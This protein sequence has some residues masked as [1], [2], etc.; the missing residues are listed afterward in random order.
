[1]TESQKLFA[2]LSG[3]VV[4]HLLFFIIVFLFLGMESVSSSSVRNPEQQE[5]APREVTVMLEELIEF[6]QLEPEPEPEPEPVPRSFVSTDL[7]Q[8]EEVAPENPRFESDRNT[9]AATELMPNFELPQ[10][11]GPTLEG[12]EAIPFLQL[13]NREYIE[14]SAAAAAADPT[15][16]QS[17]AAPAAASTQVG[18]DD[19]NVEGQS[20]APLEEI[21]NVTSR[22]EMAETDGEESETSQVRSF[23]DPNGGAFSIGAPTEK[24]DKERIAE[25]SEGAEEVG[26]RTDEAQEKTAIAQEGDGS[27]KGEAQSDSDNGS[28]QKMIGDEGLFAADFTPEERQNIVNGK[29]T[30]IGQ[31]AVDAE[32]TPMGR[33]QQSIR[34]AIA[35]IWHRYRQDNA[36]FV[37][38]G[39]LKL[40]FHVDRGGGVN[41]L[42]ILE[43]NANSVLAEFSVKAIMDAKLPPMPEEVA[44]EV[45]GGDMKM[46][47]DII[48]Y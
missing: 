30:N 46:N 7:N 20:D 22:P 38:W 45:G 12:E 28:V 48:I 34:M 27:D 19:E 41:G 33:Y 37:S 10:Q 11:E 24:E 29:L 13:Q 9:S 5:G 25:M 42:K 3:A 23:V 36:D 35:K 39:V 1:M 2:S 47:Y 16:A 15:V 31:N 26:N 14:E 17:S 43:N 40:E 44:K 4:A 8:R 21:G 18:Q 6:A 32:D